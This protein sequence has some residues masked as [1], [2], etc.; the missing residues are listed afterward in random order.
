[1]HQ[2][3]ER[4]RWQASVLAEA[5]NLL[6]QTRG[7]VGQALHAAQVH[8]DYNQTRATED[9]DLDHDERDESRRLANHYTSVIE[10]LDDYRRAL[11]MLRRII[12]R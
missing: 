12:C 9:D 1:M 6:V 3:T 8:Q 4:P 2:V 5:H 7:S 10:C 11:P